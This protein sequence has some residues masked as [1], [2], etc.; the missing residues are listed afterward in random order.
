MSEM[1]KRSA[2][3]V[4]VMIAAIFLT[5]CQSQGQADNADN[6]GMPGFHRMR[7]GQDNGVQGFRP[8]TGLGDF[9]VTGG[10]SSNQQPRP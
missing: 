3:L 5:A 9:K 7:Q 1:C 10:S 2:A 4:A 6:G 8:A